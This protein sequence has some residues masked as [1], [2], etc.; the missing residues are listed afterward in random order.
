MTV[1]KR[2]KPVCV[3]KRTTLISYPKEIF[4]LTDIIINREVPSKLGVTNIAF[5]L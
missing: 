5:H 3:I 2:E 1:N 4:P